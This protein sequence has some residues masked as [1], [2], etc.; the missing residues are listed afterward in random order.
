MGRMWDLCHGCVDP[1]TATLG[2]CGQ[3]EACATLKLS[4]TA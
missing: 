4:D 3:R 2:A 1:R